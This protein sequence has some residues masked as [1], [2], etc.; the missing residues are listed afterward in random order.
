MDLHQK[1]T[2]VEVEEEVEVRNDIDF[3]LERYLVKYIFEVKN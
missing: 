1:A 2:E 3:T